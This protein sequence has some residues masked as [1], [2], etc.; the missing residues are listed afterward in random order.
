MRLAI[1]L[2]VAL[3][4]LIS[5]SGIAYVTGALA[6]IGFV[7]TDNADFL[8][9]IPGRVFSGMDVFAFMAMP[10][11]IL[12]GEIM[13]RGGVTQALVNFSVALIGRVK[14]GLGYVNVMTSVFFA[15]ISGSAVADAAALSNTLVPAMRKQGYS[16][17]YAGA[18]TA[19][20]SIIGPII[21]PSI[22]LVFYGSIM[23]TDVAALFAGGIVPGLLLAGTLLAANAFFA[24]RGNHP[25]GKDIEVPGL[26]PAAIKALPALSLPLIILGGIVF[27]WM[28]PTE[29]AAVAVLAAI[30]VSALYGLFSRAMIWRA[31]Q[32]SIILSGSIFVTLGAAS[33]VTLLAALTHTPQ[34]LGATI[35]GLGLTGLGFLFTFLVVFIFM[36]M[37]AE[38]QIALAL[39]APLL[40]PI[41]LAQG[42]NEVHLGVVVCLTLAMGLIT[43]PLGGAVLVTST[44]TGVSYWRLIMTTLPFAL[45]E[46]ILLFV[47]LIFPEITLFLPRAMGLM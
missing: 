24:W 15:G 37:I 27:G 20:S 29:A 5:G 32:R 21:P 38:T 11:F 9:A 35:A 42:A 4:M 28:T 12:V 17:E 40:V 19:A 10:L 26:I 13:N 23:G 43:P 44:V 1:I 46:T 45:L 47:L 16:G 14:G 2:A 25:G 6:A 31:L 33:L 41:A 18:I 8:R 36:G 39:L 7:T 22:I 34:A 30:A 3:L